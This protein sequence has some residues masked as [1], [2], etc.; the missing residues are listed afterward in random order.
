MKKNFFDW[1][2]LLLAGKRKEYM[3]ELYTLFYYIYL[4]WKL[5]QAA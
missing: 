5:K 1:N 3:L 4:T 2:Q